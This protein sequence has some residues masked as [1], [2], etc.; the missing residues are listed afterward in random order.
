[1]ISNAMR[2]ADQ[3]GLPL[4]FN[5][6]QWASIRGAHQLSI[7][8]ERHHDAKQ[9]LGK[10]PMDVSSKEGRDAVRDLLM[11][12]AVENM[13]RLDKKYD[14]EMTNTQVLMGGGYLTVDNLAKMMSATTVRNSITAEQV[15]NIMKMPDGYDSGKMAY[16]LGNELLAVAQE[17]YDAYEKSKQMTM[18]NRN[19]PEKVEQLQSAQIQQPI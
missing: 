5:D 14:Q 18:Q 9:F 11:G 10:E 19:E 13:I 7:L 17:G 12:N 3:H 2:L 6:T 1:M 15:K 8:A 4:K 16:Q